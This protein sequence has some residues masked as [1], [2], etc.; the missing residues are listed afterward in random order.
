MN[1][2]KGLEKTIHHDKIFRFMGHKL[3]LIVMISLLM[4]SMISSFD[5]SDLFCQDHHAANTESEHQAH[6]VTCPECQN[7]GSISW[8]FTQSFNISVQIPMQRFA[9]R[10]TQRIVLPSEFISSIFRPPI[11]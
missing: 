6:H 4:G 10:Y 3:V 2:Y 1:G 9:S 11:A 7:H 5:N 8:M